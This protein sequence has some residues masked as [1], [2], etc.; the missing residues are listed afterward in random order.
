MVPPVRAWTEP[1]AL[2]GPDYEYDCD[3]ALINTSADSTSHTIADT[4]AASNSCDDHDA[5]CVSGVFGVL[6][7][8]TLE[9]GRSSLLL[10]GQLRASLWAL[11]RGVWGQCGSLQI[12]GGCLC[13]RCDQ[14]FDLR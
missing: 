2:A 3:D 7:E 8:G 1:L 4:N 5:H 11:F 12:R 10:L 13:G 14:L 6:R 9:Q